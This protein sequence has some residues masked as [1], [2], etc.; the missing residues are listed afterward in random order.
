MQGTMKRLRTKRMQ[1]V[2]VTT[3]A[4]LAAATALAGCTTSA[5]TS[6]K[7]TIT[8]SG[9]NQ[10]TSDTKTFGTAWDTLVANFEKDNPNIILKTNVLPLS[11]WA[12]TSA[13]QLT[14]GTA[15]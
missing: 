12:Q 2:A 6:G 11:S 5:A 1:R 9:P 3:V 14:A 8:L 15:P 7:V 13:A 4:V 10:F